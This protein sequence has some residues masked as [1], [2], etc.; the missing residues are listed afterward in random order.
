[1]RRQRVKPHGEDASAIAQAPSEQ[2]SHIDGT[3]PQYNTCLT[4]Q[5]SRTDGTKVQASEQLLEDDGASMGQGFPPPPPQQASSGY[6]LVEGCI[7]KGA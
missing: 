1:M 4:T 6:V 5:P 7:V 3:A 2:P